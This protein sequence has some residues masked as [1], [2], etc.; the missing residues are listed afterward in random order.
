MPTAFDTPAFD[1]IIVGLG[2]MGSATLLQLAR[3]GRRVL[4][5]NRWDPPHA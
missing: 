5:L 4:G 1:T 3:R 2:A